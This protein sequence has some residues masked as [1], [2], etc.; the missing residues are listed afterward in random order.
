MLLS[1][2]DHTRSLQYECI[3]EKVSV[4]MQIN[5]HELIY[6]RS[7]LGWQSTQ[8]VSFFAV[9]MNFGFSDHMYISFQYSYHT[10][11]AL[12]IVLVLASNAVFVFNVLHLSFDNGGSLQSQNVLYQFNRDVEQKKSSNSPLCLVFCFTIRTDTL[13]AFCL[14]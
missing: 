1:L 12:G 7:P 8:S 11:Q 9:P 5:S 14:V 13:S 2:L 10:V 3:C 6:W 4:L